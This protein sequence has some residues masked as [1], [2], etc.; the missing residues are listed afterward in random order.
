MCRRILTVGKL[1]RVKEPLIFAG[2]LILALGGIAVEHWA[3][4]RAGRET[5]RPARPLSAMG[6]ILVLIATG[7]WLAV[8]LTDDDNYLPGLDIVFAALVV[9]FGIVEHL[10]IASVCGNLQK[11]PPM[12]SAKLRRPGPPTARRAEPHP[13][14]P[15]PGADPRSGGGRRCRGRQ[16]GRRSGATMGGCDC[17][18][19]S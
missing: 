8:E 11:R 19:S 14:S 4:R 1:T 12:L 17:S 7:V 16:R 3:V 10:S 6:L 5:H 13:R 18:G 2:C 15:R 9:V